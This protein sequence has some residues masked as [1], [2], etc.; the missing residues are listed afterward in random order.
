[1]YAL[2]KGT[3]GKTKTGTHKKTN[4][5][6]IFQNS[7]R[8][9]LLLTH[10]NVVALDAD[11][12]GIVHFATWQTATTA[13]SSLLVFS[14]TQFRLKTNDHRHLIIA[15]ITR[16]NSRNTVS[17]CTPNR[18][19]NPTLTRSQLLRFATKQTRTQSW[20]KLDGLR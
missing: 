13:S 5:Q 12:S 7:R 20:D 8:I 11:Q 19:N 10:R 6:K 14:G 9:L 17:P 18:T 3:R 1:M 4:C 2:H 16:R 15:P